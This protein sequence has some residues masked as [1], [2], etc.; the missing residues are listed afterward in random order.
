MALNGFTNL[1]ANYKK[2]TITWDNSLDLGYGVINQGD[3]PW[4][5]SD[6]RLEFNS[7]FGKEINKHWYYSLA[8]F[9]TQLL[10]QVLLFQ[11]IQL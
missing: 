5:K 4:Q 11:M 9:R 1:F 3:Q 2:G 6:D 7:K 10:F 8:N